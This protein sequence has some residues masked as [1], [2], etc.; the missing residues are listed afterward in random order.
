MPGYAGS[1]AAE[2]M[3]I[4]HVVCRVCGHSGPPAAADQNCME[5]GSKIETATKQSQDPRSANGTYDMSAN[6]DT[7]TPQVND[8]CTSLHE[9]M[10]AQGK[11]FCTGCGSSLTEAFRDKVDCNYCQL[12]FK[13]SESEGYCP[14]CGTSPLSED[15]E[16]VLPDEMHKAKP[17][18]PQ[19]PTAAEPR[20]PDLAHPM[21][22]IACGARSV[23]VNPSTNEE[24]CSEYGHRDIGEDVEWSDNVDRDDYQNI[25][26][27]VSIAA[28]DGRSE[29]VKTLAN[30][31]VWGYRSNN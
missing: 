6:T 11:Q 21:D 1:P 13:L 18:Q 8:S 12:S 5:C 26:N 19:N 2:R 17:E 28:S 15:H 7:K 27:H 4:P 29:T 31:L 23:N 3:R 25:V 14:R 16:P 24:I 30:D 10:L 9:S 22:C 20:R